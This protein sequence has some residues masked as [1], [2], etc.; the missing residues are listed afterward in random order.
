[1]KPAA[2]L[3]ISII[4]NREVRRAIPDSPVSRFLGNFMLW[5]LFCVSGDFLLFVLVVVIQAA[6]ADLRLHIVADVFAGSADQVAGA[7]AEKEVNGANVILGEAS[8]YD[9]LI[10]VKRRRD[11]LIDEVITERQSL[12]NLC[13]WLG[14]VEISLANQ[15]D[16]FWVRQ[17]IQVVADHPNSSRSGG[18]IGAVVCRRTGVGNFG[19]D[20][21][22]GTGRRTG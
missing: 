3:K 15:A 2:R 8:G 21:F 14:R 5:P 19:L 16:V 7:S 4:S 20:L 13:H 12:N 18:R 9:R 1:M 11:V 10:G 22:Q 6:H 17:F